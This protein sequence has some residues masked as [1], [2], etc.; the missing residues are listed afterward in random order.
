MDPEIPSA[1]SKAKKDV[2][3]PDMFIC[4]ISMQIM[5]DPQIS[6]CGHMFDRDSILRWLKG[7][8]DPEKREIKRG[9]P[10]CNKDMELGSLSPC[11]PV[12]KAIDEFMKAS[13]GNTLSGSTNTNISN[14]SLESNQSGLSFESTK[15]GAVV[16]EPRP[17]SSSSM[18]KIKESIIRTINGEGSRKRKKVWCILTPVVQGTF[19]KIHVFREDFQIGR[20]PGADFVLKLQEVSHFH[21]KI[22]RRKQASTGKY[23]I[24]IEDKSTN[25]TFI[26]GQ[27]VGKTNLN[28]AFHGDCLSIGRKFIIE[29][30]VPQLENWIDWVF[31]GSSDLQERQNDIKK[32]KSI[33]RFDTLLQFS[34]S[35]YGK[36]GIASESVVNTVMLAL[37]AWRYDHRFPCIITLI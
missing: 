12:K 27:K 10:V 36:L 30:D 4:P 5:T 22:R 23:E 26:N 11:Y 8:Y 32:L 20:N 37:K 13:E 15:S 34:D 18:S 31:A 3:I 35:D 1:I 28:S 16:E 17:R 6:K 14:Q 24:I 29:K 19:E 33:D 7:D 21:C 25:G 9:C 2:E